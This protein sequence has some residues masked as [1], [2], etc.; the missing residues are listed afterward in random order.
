[1]REGYLRE[2][3]ALAVFY[4]AMLQPYGRRFRDG[5]TV[6]DLHHALDAVFFGFAFRG[7]VVPEAM[8]PESEHGARLFAKAVEAIV[9]AFTEEG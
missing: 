2:T 6:E 9:L 1:M 5:L 8:G 7:R 4:S 3:E